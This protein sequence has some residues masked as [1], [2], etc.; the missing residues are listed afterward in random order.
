MEAAVLR[1]P[2][3]IHNARE[4]DGQIIVGKDILELLSSSMYVDPL[5]VYREYIQNSVDAIDQAVEFGI[6]PSH[7]EGRIDIILDHVNRRAVVR[8]NGIGMASV[9]FVTRMTSF[10]AS[11]KRGGSARGFRGVGRLAGL[12]YC[13]ELIFRA[14]GVGEDFVTAITWNC[15]LLRELLLDAK[16]LGD[17]EKLVRQVVKVTKLE[18]AEFPERFFEVEMVKPRRIGNDILLNETIVGLYLSQVAPCPFSPEF[19]FGHE[20][21]EFLSEAVRHY[22]MYLNGCHEPLYRPYGE[23]IGYSERE[24]SNFQRLRTLRI[25]TVDGKPAAIGWIIHHDD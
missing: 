20:I 8:D 9:E 25:Y 17:L 11:S 6:L 1:L 13:Q 15:R 22:R 5:T 12:G 3:K 14:R 19:K 2:A 16:Y 7:E 18:A 10:G 4:F 24:H 23:F 21:N